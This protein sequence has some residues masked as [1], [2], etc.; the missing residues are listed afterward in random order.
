MKSWQGLFKKGFLESRMLVISSFFFSFF[1]CFL[2]SIV[3]VEPYRQYHF[4][5]W[6]FQVEDET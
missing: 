5:H 3:C 2:A 1:E 4:Q 6:S